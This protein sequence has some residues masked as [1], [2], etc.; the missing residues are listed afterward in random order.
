MEESDYTY[1]RVRS[2]SSQDTSHTDPLLLLKAHEESLEEHVCSQ[3]RVSHLASDDRKLA[4][5]LAGNLDEK[6]YLSIS[7]EEACTNLGASR[8]L[9]ESAPAALQAT[10]PTG[11]GTRD[12]RE[13]LLLQIRKD[14]SACVGA[15]A[16]VT[17]HLALL[18]QGKFK[19]IGNRLKLPEQQTVQIIAYIK[20]LNP[21]PGQ[22][23][24]CFHHH[25]YVIPDAYIHKDELG[26]TIHMNTKYMPRISMNSEYTRFVKERQE[27]ASF[28]LKDKFKSAG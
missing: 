25:P 8:E 27:E 17:E 15:Y 26:F 7:L 13:C 11:V 14:P 9:A 2:A 19:E 1:W 23:Y 12:M 24:P 28:Y 20:T 3:L 4:I 10:E 18:A 22:A 6:G 16:C 5:Y 21:W